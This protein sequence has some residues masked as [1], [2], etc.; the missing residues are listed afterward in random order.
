MS[1]EMETSMCDITM[2][3]QKYD[4]TVFAILYHLKVYFFHRAW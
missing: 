4:D 3:A 1:K 2:I